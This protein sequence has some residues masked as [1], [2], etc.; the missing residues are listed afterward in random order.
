VRAGAGPRSRA[1]VFYNPAMAFDR[2]LAVAAIRSLWPADGPVRSGWEVTPATG[3][4][5]LRL[6]GETGAFSSFAFTEPGE[7][8]FAVLARNTEGRSG[9][10]ASRMDG[11]RPPPGAPF[12]FVDVDPYGSPLPFLPGALGAVRPGGVLAVTATD[13]MVL[14][15]AQPAATLRL[16]GSRPVRGR[17]GPE[18]GLRILL[19][20]VARHAR[21]VGRVARPWLAYAHAHY[22]RAYFV[23]DASSSDPDPVGL[24]DP[25]TWDGP[26]VGDR[27][28]YGPLWLG[29]LFDRERVRRIEVPPTA[30]RRREL[31]A[32][33]TTIA[34]EAEVA[35]P[36][37][38]ESNALAA[39]LRLP[40]PPSIA[41]LCTGLRESGFHVARTHAR[42]EGVRTDAPRPVVESVARRLAAGRQSQNARVRA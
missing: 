2:D 25:T 7:A 10:H 20:A 1:P 33:L 5:G 9:A 27:G 23:V 12:D 4:R 22:V 11:R 31:A 15:G 18:S 8:A 14:A 39:R 6:L 26:P 30:E 16:Y 34:D 3:I 32:F 19:A 28:P 21:S 35:S 36:F 17:L 38:Y 24:I 13:M 40:L 37:Y 42:P 41:E 29:A